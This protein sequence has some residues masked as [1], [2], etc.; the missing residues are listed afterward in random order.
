MGFVWRRFGLRLV[1]AA[2]PFPLLNASYC[3]P[4]KQFRG[5]ETHS[6]PHPVYAMSDYKAPEPPLPAKEFLRA[7]IT[8]VAIALHAF[9]RAFDHLLVLGFFHAAF[10][11][12]FGNGLF[13]IR[14][15]VSGLARG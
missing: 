2:P 3:Q 8:Q 15:H 10:D 7:R 14:F 6:H 4:R 9:A 13:V 12:R 5:G 1:H 11:E